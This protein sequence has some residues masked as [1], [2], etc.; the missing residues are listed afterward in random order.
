MLDNAEKFREFPELKG[1]DK[2]YSK[3]TLSF[4][5]DVEKKLNGIAKVKKEEPLPQQDYGGDLTTNLPLSFGEDPELHHTAADG[6]GN[7]LSISEIS[8]NEAPSPINRT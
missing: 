5:S 8:F 3:V 7:P 1:I 4:D 2:S 6:S